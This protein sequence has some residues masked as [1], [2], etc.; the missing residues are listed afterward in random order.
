[1]AVWCHVL[2]LRDRSDFLAGDQGHHISRSRRDIGAP[3]YTIHQLLRVKGGS[4]QEFEEVLRLFL[5]RG[6]D[7]NVG[8]VPEATLLGAGL[9][10][11]LQGSTV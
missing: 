4:F 11:Q 2:Y 3:W 1:M 9:W 6:A 8:N 7:I 5:D 10:G